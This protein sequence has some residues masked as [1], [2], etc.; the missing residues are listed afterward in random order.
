[1]FSALSD[2]N[3]GNIP[4]EDHLRIFLRC[5]NQAVIGFYFEYS[6]IIAQTYCSSYSNKYCPC[7]VPLHIGT[8]GTVLLLLISYFR[9]CYF[10]FSDDLRLRRML[11]ITRYIFMV[12][13]HILVAIGNDRSPITMIVGR[14]AC[15]PTHSAIC[16][17]E[18]S[19]LVHI[20]LFIE[21]AWTLVDTS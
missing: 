15:Y 9:A 10:R 3:Q 21:R 2:R 17:R 19:F 20:Y 11:Q 8:V 18:L 1:M 12:G 5:C 14:S 16:Q 4:Y 13:L 6:V 7:I